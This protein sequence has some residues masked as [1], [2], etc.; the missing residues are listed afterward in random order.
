MS[1]RIAFATTCKNRTQYLRETLPR[2]LADNSQALF[3]VLDYGSED[4]LQSW[5][6]TELS[7]ELESGRL[8]CYSYRDNPQFEMAHAKN[9]ASRA[10]ILEGAEIVVNVDADNKTNTGFDRYL[11]RQFARHGEN[12][13]MSARMKKGVLPRGINGRI[14]VTKEAFLASGGYDEAKFRTWGSDDKDFNLRLRHLGYQDVEIAPFYLD[15]ITH[16]NRVR[17]REWPELADKPDEFFAVNRGTITHGVVNGGRVGVGTVFK[18]YDF[19]TPIR[20]PPISATRIFGI[21]LHRT[22]TTSLHRALETLGFNSWHWSPVGNLAPAHAAREMWLEMVNQGRSE[23]LERSQALSDLPIPMLYDRLDAA[24]PGSKF[25]LTERGESKWLRAAAEHFS[26]L[27]PY[28]AEWPPFTHRL[29]EILYGRQDFEPD[30]FLARYR[31]HNAEVRDY[32]RDRPGDLLVMD[33]DDGAGWDALCRF[34]ECPVPD[35]PYPYANGS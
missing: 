35:K 27:N 12:I 32:F 17:F 24:Y 21:G 20:I 4:D 16:N 9:L 28:R 22:A 26:P 25:I 6:T 1:R 14:A 2:N 15:G 13:F 11:D 31:C 33:M 7:A 19:A 10:A 18:N 3:V 23:T 8:V 30:V 5:I 29:H 34:L